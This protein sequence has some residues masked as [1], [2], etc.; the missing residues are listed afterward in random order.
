MPL[1]YEILQSV[2]LALCRFLNWC[3]ALARCHF[4]AAAVATCR[5]NILRLPARDRTAVPFPLAWSAISLRQYFRLSL[6]S[7][8]IPLR[9]SPAEGR[10]QRLTTTTA[11]L[12]T[13]SWTRRPKSV[14]HIGYMLGG[15]RRHASPPQARALQP[16]GPLDPNRPTSIR[17]VDSPTV[18]RSDPANNRASNEHGEISSWMALSPGLRDQPRHP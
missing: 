3:I 7:S 13:W 6:P 5:T 2:S 12:S 11:A 8:N 14:Q 18:V 17:Q 16:C 4:A 9:Y 1:L 15:A 10:C